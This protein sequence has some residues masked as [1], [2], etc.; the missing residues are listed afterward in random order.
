M[1]QEKWTKRD[2]KRRKRRSRKPDSGRS[3]FVIQELQRKRAR[4]IARKEKDELLQR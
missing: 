2:R 4:K 1:R 3:L